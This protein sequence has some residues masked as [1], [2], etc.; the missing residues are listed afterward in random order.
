MSEGLRYL[1]RLE[2]KTLTALAEVLVIGEEEQLTPEEI[3][4]NV[5]RYLAT[6]GARRK[7]IVR[8]A[9]LGLHLYPLLKLRAPFSAMAPQKR[10]DFVKRHFLTDV[11]ERRII[12]PWRK[13]VQAMIRVAQQLVYLGYYGDKRTFASVGYVPFSERPRFASEMSKVEQHRL[14]VSALT[15]ADL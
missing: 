11:A 13:V 7:W 15:P 10:L 1:S 14:R 4:H 6:F 9:L 2:F 3:G 12:E 8:L 5:D